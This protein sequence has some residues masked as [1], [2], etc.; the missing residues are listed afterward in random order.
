MAV[1]EAMIAEG[2]GSSKDECMGSNDCRW[3]G[4]H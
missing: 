3:S 1:W 2:L 4:E